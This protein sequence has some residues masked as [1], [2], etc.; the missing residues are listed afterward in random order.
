MHKNI[1]GLS[2]H[3][4]LTQPKTGLCLKL[5]HKAKSE[6]ESPYR[7]RSKSSPTRF[8]G[9]EIPFHLAIQC[10]QQATAER[11]HRFSQGLK[12]QAT[13]TTAQTLGLSLHRDF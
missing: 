13:V 11:S 2:S 9:Q 10:E 3:K 8:L 1:P 4:A 12:K 5:S 7:T 6:L